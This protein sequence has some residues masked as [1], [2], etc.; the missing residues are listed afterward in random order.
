MV[1]QPGMVHLTA[2]VRA[3]SSFL[4]EP[5]EGLE[6]AKEGPFVPVGGSRLLELLK[7]LPTVVIERYFAFKLISLLLEVHE[8]VDWIDA[9]LKSC[10]EERMSALQSGVPTAGGHELACWPKLSMWCCDGM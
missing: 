6:N 9:C 7:S 10:S 5:T 8:L 3:V 1:L 4:I 2:G